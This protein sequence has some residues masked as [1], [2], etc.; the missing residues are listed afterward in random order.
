MLLRLSLMVVLT[1]DGKTQQAGV[2]SVQETLEQA[3]SRVA[4]HPVAV[5][6]AGRTDAVFMLLA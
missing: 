5:H 3:I 4:N 2:I 6:G 1:K